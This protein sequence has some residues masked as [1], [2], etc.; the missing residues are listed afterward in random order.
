M[1]PDD[2]ATDRDAVTSETKGRA[3]LIEDALS[4]TGIFRGELNRQGSVCA[5]LP[6][7]FN[8]R[9][10]SQQGV[11]LLSFAEGLSFR[12]SLHRMM[13]DCVGWSKVFDLASSAMDEVE[14]R[15]FQM[16]IHEQSLFPDIDGLAGLIR[17]K[18]RLQWR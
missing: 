1:Y 11:F 9:L 14:E 15:L 5:A 18:A 3:K 12:S 2:F 4:A 16:N 8:P 6:P 17:Q 10:A 13:S 7:E